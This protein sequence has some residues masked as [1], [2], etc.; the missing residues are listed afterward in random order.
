ME[1]P[2]T[3]IQVQSTP[4]THATARTT[5]PPGQD[6]DSHL[7]GSPGTNLTEEV[8]VC[9]TNNTA[10]SVHT[11]TRETSISE[12]SAFTDKDESSREGTTGN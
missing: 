4:Q 1:T 6:S 5:T 3:V 10:V 11:L 9:D 8:V 2:E 7:N 12:L